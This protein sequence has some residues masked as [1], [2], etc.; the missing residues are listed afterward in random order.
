M[1]HKK[2]TLFAMLTCLLTTQVHAAGCQLHK[3]AVIPLTP[4]Q[5]EIFHAKS[6]SVELRFHSESNDPEVDA[7]PEPPLQVLQ[8][9]TNTQCEINS[10][11]WVRKDVYL[12]QDEK[13]LVTHEY[14]GSNDFLMFYNTGSCA[15]LHEL[16]VSA[17]WWNISGDTIRIQNMEQAKK[18]PAA[19]QY[20][21]DA[22]CQPV[23]KFSK[24][25]KSGQ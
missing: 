12:S 15:K 14:S 17:S 2:T 13:V 22:S 8:L 24:P 4:G 6:K 1:L 10:G 3:L 18:T 20:M 9:A 11:I 23:A 21:L 16:D 5:Y 19:K 7:F 25:G